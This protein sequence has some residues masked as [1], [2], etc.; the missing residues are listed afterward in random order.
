ML[1]M[2]ESARSTNNYNLEPFKLKPRF[3]E[4]EFG[5]GRVWLLGTTAG[6][7]RRLGRLGLRGRS[8]LSRVGS[9]MGGR[10]GM[11]PRS[12][13]GTLDGVGA[14]SEFP[15]LVKMLFP[16]E[17]LSVQ[18]HPDDEQAKA[19][20]LPRGKTECWYV[21]EAEP[22]ATVACGLQE[23]VTVEELR[24]AAGDG[25]MEVLLKMVPVSEGDMILV[26]AGT[27]HAIGAGGDA[28]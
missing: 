17:K 6:Q 9:T 15:L 23:G 28:A 18:V 20:G 10:W 13:R 7:V 12:V 24:A 4:R 14:G 19:L 8:A 27:V 26:D 21:L 16:D 2:S 22:G 25:S 1:T 3:V 5:G 11:C